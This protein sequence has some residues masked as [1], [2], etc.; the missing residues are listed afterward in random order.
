MLFFIDIT[1]ESQDTCYS[2]LGR[3][4]ESSKDAIFE[5]NTLLF[6]SVRC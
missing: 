5:V 1:C 2:A 3:D 4:F 6:G